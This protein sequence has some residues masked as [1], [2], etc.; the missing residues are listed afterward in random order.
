MLR[1]SSMDHAYQLSASINEVAAEEMF[2]WRG[3]MCQVNSKS[4]IRRMNMEH[5]SSA[6]SCRSVQVGPFLLGAKSR[7]RCEADTDIKHFECWRNKGWISFRRFARLCALDLVLLL[8]IVQIRFWW[9]KTQV[10]V[11]FR[12]QITNLIIIIITIISEI[13]ACHILSRWKI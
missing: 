10:C 9:K 1:K 4:Q 3:S 8:Q 2:K 5:L 7:H 11:M 13:D 12:Y 6:P